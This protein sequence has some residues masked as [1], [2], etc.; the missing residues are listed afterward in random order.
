MAEGDFSTEGEESFLLAYLSLFGGI[1]YFLWLRR[2]KTNYDGIPSVGFSGPV[3][4]FVTALRWMRDQNGVVEEG[5]AKF[6]NRIFR[7]PTLT[8]WIVVVAGS[9]YVEELRKAPEDEISASD[10]MKETL[11]VPSTISSKLL[12]DPELKALLGSQLTRKLQDFLP[13]IQSVASELMKTLIPSE[14]D[15]W[16]YID[17]HSTMMCICIQAVNRALLGAN[18]SR[19]PQFIEQISTFLQST[20]RYTSK[21]RRLPKILQPLYIIMFTSVPQVKRRLRAMLADTPADTHRIDIG[22]DF[23]PDDMITWFNGREIESE[24]PLDELVDHVLLVNYLAVYPMIQVMSQV[25]RK[26]ATLPD[27]RRSLR[28]EAEE[29]TK[30]GVWT[31]ASVDRMHKIDSFLKETMRLD[32]NALSPFFPTLTMSRKCR[33]P[34]TFS[35]GTTVPHGALLFVGSQLLHT[36]SRYYRNPKVFEPLRFIPPQRTSS[37]PLISPASSSESQSSLSSWASSS[38]AT[39]LPVSLTLPATSSKFLAWGHGKHACPG[40]FFAASVM[41]VMLAQF[42]LEFDIRPPPVHD[43]SSTSNSS[44]SAKMLP[45]IEIRR[46]QH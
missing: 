4:S 20:D 26:L 12:T 8:R 5:Y 34:I 31:K 37:S 42:I 25:L 40:R 19:D 41:K 21:S 14:E 15:D 33:R 36:D 22:E 18:L 16:K 35:D 43:I 24:M 13:D 17:E 29:A 7:Y 27:S 30:H 9:K 45:W 28:K 44:E 3:L 11:G 1:V 10:A 38:S 23:P 2:D 46:Y 39:L 6:P 32:T